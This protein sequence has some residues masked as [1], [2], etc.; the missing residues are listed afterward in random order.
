MALR[1][2]QTACR[3]W[4]SWRRG[5]TA[6]GRYPWR[7]WCVSAADQTAAGCQIALHTLSF[8]VRPDRRGTVHRK[9]ISVRRPSRVRPER[10]SAHCHEDKNA[11]VGVE[12]A[13]RECRQW[14]LQE[15]PSVCKLLG[16]DSAALSR[17]GTAAIDHICSA[18]TD[19]R[20]PV[21]LWPTAARQC[22]DLRSRD[23]SSRCESHG[24]KSALSAAASTT[25]HY[26][27]AP[28]R[29]ASRIELT[30][31]RRAP[32]PLRRSPRRS[33]RRR[34][35]VPPRKPQLRG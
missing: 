5:K 3:S 29:G 17:C 30:L 9:P 27:F 4:A 19:K 32:W 14:C 12:G 20:Q 16:G 11:A 18:M 35:P 22:K 23:G 26:R 7:G 1:C 31:T 10:I 24:P 2:C 28:H 21:S 13:A 15:Q 6:V 33:R 34:R 25:R 8:R